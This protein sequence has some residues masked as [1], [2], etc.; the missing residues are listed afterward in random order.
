MG[1]IAGRPAR[2]PCHLRS[3]AICHRGH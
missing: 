3:S 2:V 1:E